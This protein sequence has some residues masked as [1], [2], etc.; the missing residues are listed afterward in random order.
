M[1]G[2]AMMGR[3]VGATIEG[4]VRR[5]RCGAFGMYGAD[6]VDSSPRTVYNGNA[7]TTDYN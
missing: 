4:S 7:H 6:F 5:A 3:S 1:S 2:E